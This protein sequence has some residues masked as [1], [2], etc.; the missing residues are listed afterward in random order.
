MKSTYIH[1]FTEHDRLWDDEDF[2]YQFHLRLRQEIDQE[3]TEV[4]AAQ[5]EREHFADL[6]TI[7]DV[8]NV[9]GEHF[10]VGVAVSRRRQATV[11][12]AFEQPHDPAENLVIQAQ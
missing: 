5:V 1:T 7:G 8:A 2:R 6:R 10:H 4:R 12:L 3:N 9:G 11:H